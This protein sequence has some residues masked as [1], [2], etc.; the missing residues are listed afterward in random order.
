MVIL[1][2]QASKSVSFS[3][4]AKHWDRYSL[5]MAAKYCELVSL[6]YH[7]V[8]RYTDATKSKT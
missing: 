7:F 3:I 2:V 8:D 1:V 6:Q 5:N 4:L